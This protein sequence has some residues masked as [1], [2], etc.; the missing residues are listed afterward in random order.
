MGTVQWNKVSESDNSGKI[1]FLKLTSGSTYRI[2]PI[3]Y[4]TG[5]FKYFYKNKEG[6]LRTAICMDP[7]TC[8]VRARHP[9]L[10]KPSERF[11]VYVIDRADDKLKIIEG[12]KPLFRP[13]GSHFE[14]TGA[15]PGG[16]KD[17]SDWMI[18]V[19]GGGIKTR[20]DTTFLD[21]TPLTKDEQDMIRNAI[22]GDIKNS[23]SELFKPDTPEQ[24]ERKLFGEFTGK[25]PENGSGA[26]DIEPEVAD[27]PSASAENSDMNW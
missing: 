14:A 2:R 15:N 17:G 10:Q 19:S 12:G 23:L 26:D 3:Y 27:A 25:E 4:P 13:L 16:T 24:I 20:Y 6:K 9:E 5:F 1:G 18:K 11:V 8:P 7:D 22:C 21:K